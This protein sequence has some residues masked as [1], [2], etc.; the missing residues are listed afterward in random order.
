MKYLKNRKYTVLFFFTVLLI[1]F[2]L[3]SCDQ[4]IKNKN[5]ETKKIENQKQAISDNKNEAK[6]LLMLSKDNQVVIKLSKALQKVINKDSNV[7]LA[8]T[9]EKTHLE[10]ADDLYDVATD[11]LISIPNYSELAF[12]KAIIDINQTNKIAALKKLKSKIDNQLFLLDKL[13]KVTNSKEFKTV[14]VEADSKITDSLNKTKNLIND[15][16]KN[17]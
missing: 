6:L 14:L 1:G 5:L 15:L 2:N 17:S 9:I 13:Y 8:K 10:I 4:L 16:K 11:K 3:N 7:K 12:N